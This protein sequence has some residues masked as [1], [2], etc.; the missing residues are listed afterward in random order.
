MADDFDEDHSTEI[1]FHGSG[2]TDDDSQVMETLYR[3][4]KGRYWMKRNGGF[5]SSTVGAVEREWMTLPQARA[6]L[7]LVGKEKAAEEL[8]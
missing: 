2:S 1:A 5:N 8:I 4:P 6:W 3:H 7:V